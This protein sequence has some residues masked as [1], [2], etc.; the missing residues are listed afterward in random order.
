MTNTC[1][2]VLDD[3]AACDCDLDVEVKVEVE[4]VNVDAGGAAD[5]AL[6]LVCVLVLVLDVVEG[7]DPPRLLPGHSA[8][9]PRSF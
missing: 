4:V 6:V 8:R 7:V 3:C 5:V 2:D 1:D 9:M